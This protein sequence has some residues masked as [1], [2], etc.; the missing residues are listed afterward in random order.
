MAR[1]IQRNVNSYVQE[2]AKEGVSILALAKRENYPPSLLSRYIVEQVA[3]LP[4]G[5]KGLTKSM[6]NPIEVLRD[7]NLILP[8]YQESELHRTDSK[9]VE[10]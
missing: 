4:D 8:K 2:Y 5:K 3:Q 6:R 10:G 1:Q 7:P 9:A